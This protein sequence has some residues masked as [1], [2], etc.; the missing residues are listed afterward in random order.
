MI[1]LYPATDGQQTG[2]NFV[3]DKHVDG[4]MWIIQVDIQLVS[5][6]MY[7]DINAA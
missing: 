1:P 7:S 6:N 3:A 4:D 5:G 2:D